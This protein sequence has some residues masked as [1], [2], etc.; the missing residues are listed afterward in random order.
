VSRRL[1]TCS[2]LGLALALPLVSS[3]AL[4]GT[5]TA[6]ATYVGGTDNSTVVCGDDAGVGGACFVLQGGEVSVD[7]EITDATTTPVGAYW[8][9]TYGVCNGGG[10]GMPECGEVPL[11]SGL[12]CG[13]AAG[14][15]VPPSATRLKLAI[16]GPAQQAA[17]CSVTDGTP[18][19]AT[20]GTIAAT[21]ATP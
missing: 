5:R 1:L 21:F 4:A 16:L 18:R 14:I 12:I 19:V 20:T 15:A 11:S 17:F 7:L 2:L 10:Y 9:F 13:P 3:P 6:T 8:G